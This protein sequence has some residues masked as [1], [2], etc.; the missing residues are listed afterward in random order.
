MSIMQN[1]FATCLFHIAQQQ[2]STSRFLIL[3]VPVPP[4]VLFFFIFVIFV[5]SLISDL[6]VANG[7]RNTVSFNT[8]SFLPPSQPLHKA[9]IALYLPD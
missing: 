1:S 6:P 8:V 3:E 2:P 5:D 9:L 4:A 7:C